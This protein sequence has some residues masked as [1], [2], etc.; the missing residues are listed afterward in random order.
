[1]Y[2]S[3]YNF[4]YERANIT[5]PW[6]YWDGAFS[7]EEIAKIINQFDNNSMEDST[8]VG[9]TSQSETE[10]VR[11]SKI[12]F[13]GYDDT[14]SWIFMRFNDV[15]EKLNDR[16]Y[17]Y[18]LNGYEKIQYTV[19]DA[20]YEGKY[21][22]HQDMIHGPNA[23]PDTRKLT[24]CM[25]LTEPNVDYQGGEFQIQL[26]T[27]PDTINITKGRIVAFPSYILHRVSPLSQG[28]RKSLVIWVTGPKF[29]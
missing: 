26:G 25:N 15:I 19:Y 16:F 18:S 5:F 20:Q 10:R 22:W 11:R 1:M 6:V 28:V 27:E 3:I 4:P 23:M 7:E 12:N 24:V 14:T 21:D 13:F 29:V 8:I 2:K 17:N 9:S